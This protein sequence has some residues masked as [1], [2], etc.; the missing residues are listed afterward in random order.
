M[1]LSDVERL[2]FPSTRKRHLEAP[3]LSAKRARSERTPP[4]L[5]KPSPIVKVH[6]RKNDD[7]YVTFTIHLNYICH[8]SPY[9]YAAFH[10]RFQEG[11]KQEMKMEDTD[12]LVFGIFVNWLYT[13]TIYTEAGELPKCST[14]VNLWILADHVLV[15]RLQNHALVS[16]DA[17]RVSAKRIPARLFQRIYENTAPESPLR[18]YLIDYCVNTV[19]EIATPESY[20]SQLL[21]DIVN[22][23]RMQMKAQLKSERRSTRWELSTE[24]LAQ[25]AV[26]E[27]V[28][29]NI[30]QRY[31][32]S[33]DIDDRN[34][35]EETL[36]E[37]SLK[38]SGQTEDED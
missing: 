6:V 28:D 31:E 19:R 26:D 16:L 13:Q 22:E 34:A 29:F 7:D 2:L 36:V 23:T 38:K 11:E 35:E 18:S 4:N 3:E 17:A 1:P 5:V 20:P 8:Y 24:D 27:D 30:E 32:L 10:G 21:A 12:P 9:F 37:E 25:Y 14:L 33:D 15:P